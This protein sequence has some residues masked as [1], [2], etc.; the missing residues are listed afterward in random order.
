MP[1]VGLFVCEC[2]PNI[3]ERVDVDALV[4]FGRGLEHVALCKPAG[5]LCSV[6]GQQELVADIVDNDLTHLVVA[7]CSPREHEKTFAAVCEKAGIN[8]YLMQMVNIREQCTWVVEDREAAGAKARTLIRAGVARVVLH[9][10]LEAKDMDSNSAVLVVGAGVAGIESA[11]VLAQRG[12][13]VYVVEKSPCV[14]GHANRYEE[15]FPVMECGSCMLE[16]RLDDLLHKDNITVLTYS[17]VE[18]VLGFYGNFTVQVRKRARR[19]SAEA[20]FGCDECMKAC[21]VNSI[22]NEFNEGLDTRSAIYIPYPGSLPN[23]A[24]IDDKQCLRFQGQEC[25]AC[26]DACPFGAVDFAQEDE[27]LSLEVGSVV[28]SPG[29][30]VFDCQQIPGLGYGVI[31]EVYTSL[32]FEA[33]LS[34]GG[35]T[36]G[37]LLTR[38][39]REPSSIAFVHCIGSR[40]DRFNEYCSGACCMYTLKFSHLARQKLPD[41]QLIDIHRDLS[42]A[43]KG[44]LGLLKSTDQDKVSFVRTSAPDDIH[45]EQVD[46]KCRL[47]VPIPG[48]GTS[49]VLADMVVLSPSLEPAKDTG[50]LAKLFGV[51]LDDFGFFEEQHGRLG[52]VNTN[53]E[54]VHVAGCA[55]GP[56]DIQGAVV[57]GAAAAGKIL[58]VLVPGEKIELQ[59]ITAHSDE[60]KCGGCKVCIAVCPFNAVTYLADDSRASVNEALCHGCGTCAAA[61]P[62]GAMLARHFTS[63]QLFAEIEGLVS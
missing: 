55:H 58:G 62:S 12:R 60:D 2:G 56:T 13:Q 11:L 32:E 59:T 17:E 43:G 28:L 47:T 27:V 7:G 6:D 42:L 4:E 41:A 16:P 52:A 54:G 8:P 23:V 63:Q 20:C 61:C 51:P 5:L 38:D 25:T 31:P 44:H 45:V 37:K 1:R 14:G 40:S 29:F 36:E 15:V 10:A 3:K 57:Q 53:I 49:E 18:E 46:G 39:G 35:P 26:A 50:S 34:S 19:V 33:L 9:K 24:V 48:G 30:S 22:P 21:P